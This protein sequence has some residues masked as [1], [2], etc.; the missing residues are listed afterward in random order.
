MK[1]KLLLAALCVVSALGM[2]AQTDVTSTYLTNAD[3]SQT[4]ALD[5]GLC[6]Y[7]KDMGE[8][9]TTYYGLQAI[10]GW[11]S[12][13]LSGDNSNSTYP[14][15]GMG[16]AVFAYGSDQLMMGNNTK[17]P[18]ADPDGNS[19]NCLGF[20]GVWGCGGYYY[21]E[22]TLA[23]GK[24]T[25]NIPVYNQSGTQANTSYIGW[26]P[27]SGTSYT[28]AT[29]PTVGAWTT[30]TASFT[31]TN[32]TTGKICLGYKSTGSGS[33]ANAM[34]YFDKV[35]ILYTAA[36]VK[37]VLSTAL[38]AATNANATLN[39]SD[40]ASAIATAQSV[41]DSTTAT[42]DEVNAAA[43]TL[44][45]A[46]E[47]AMSAAGDVTGIFL[48]NPG[49]E[50]CTVTTSNAAAA[51]N[52]APLD[53][54]GE[55]TQASSA[56]WSSSAV[57]AY[58]GDGQVN[59]ASAPSADNA[60]N[61]GNAL[62]VS[63]GWGGT[64]TYQSPS[65]TLPAGVYTLQVN[66]YNN[67]SGVTQ[68]ASKFGFVPTEGS[69]TLSTKTSFAYATW[70][71]D[72]VTVTLNE[73]TE[74]VIQ[75]GG[76]AISGGSGANAKVF[77][78]NIT[79][80]YQSFLA[81]AKAQWDDAV[82]AAGE[83]KTD[84]PQVTGSEL[85][86]L[87][88]ELAKAEPTTV[89]GYNEAK[90]ALEAATA[91]FIAAAPA[92]NALATEITYA[93]TLSVNTDDATTALN[94]ADATAESVV[95]ACQAL[96][97][98]EYTTIKVA[99]PNDL[100]SLLGDWDKGNYD[101]TKGQGYVGSET[102]FDK[103]S[104]SATDLSS[105]KTVT[106]PA[107]SYTVMVAGRGVSTTT[108]NLS[109]KVGDA[110]AVS[111][112]FLMSGDTGKGIDTE[113]AT[114]FSGEGT[115][116]NNN[117]GRGWQ[118]RYI[119]FSLTDASEVTLSI[120]GHL[121]NG[122]W[123]SFYAPVLLADDATVLNISLADLAAA[124]LAANDATSEVSTL[125]TT[126]AQTTNPA[127]D[128]VTYQTVVGGS[129]AAALAAAVQAAGS[130]DAASIDA[131]Q[132]AT[133]ALTESTTAYN[134]AKP[135]YERAAMVIAIASVYSVDVTA[136]QATIENSE[137]TAE[138]IAAS[139][140]TI[141]ST[142]AGTALA[143]SKA[144]QAGFEKD[145]Y[146]PYNNVQGFALV[147]TAT[148][149][150]ANPANYTNEQL[151]QTFAAIKGYTW[152]Q[153]TEDVDAIYNGMFDSAVEGDWGLTGW[154][155]TNAWGQQRTGIEGDYATAYY[156]QPGSLKYGDTGVY[157]MP[158]AENT[159]YKLTFAY[160][161]HENN[162]NK[163]VTVSVLNGAPEGLAATEFEGNGSTSE[164]K[165]VETFFQTGAAGDYVLTL[166]NSGNTWMTGVSLVKATSTSA[167]MTVKANKWGTFIAPF[168]V[169]IPAGINAY[170]VTGVDDNGYM[171][172]EQVETTIPAN[173]PVVLENTTDALIDEDFE[174]PNLATADS[175]TEGALTGVYTASEIPVSTETVK[176]YVLQTQNDVQAFYIVNDPT[177]AFTATPNRCYLT[178][179]ASTE[180]APRAIFID[181][182]GDATGIKGVD[183]QIAKGKVK[184]IYS[185]NGTEL[186]QLQKGLNIVKMADGKV[187]KVYVK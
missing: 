31:L 67:L 39:N 24:Y 89:E 185:A 109:V 139:A 124:V 107:G 4:T 88:E 55:W 186:N 176:T 156:N 15:S 70:E 142:F 164:W 127:A 30:L 18:A 112:P 144:A 100:T 116:S 25:I 99:Y 38:T 169:A 13:V 29:N 155:R 23:A 82:A 145:E 175:Y 163:G 162:S 187:Q 120:S 168:E 174:G 121:N 2:R 151:Y 113:G 181:E 132:A 105:S 161:S 141:I 61:S 64:V 17:A 183:G 81:G 159:W 74:G 75:V 143:S 41:Y 130:V 60:G 43:A 129:E 137:T 150:G 166:A 140:N 128:E 7:G 184:G 33:G 78:D 42:Q 66:A 95:A 36:V 71:T 3:F 117:N 111:T 53:I 27:N 104:G 160:R 178:V 102:Y 123:Q 171:V 56:A 83:A 59:G 152:T 65:V 51:G 85:A 26:I 46:T 90:E 173:T 69:A 96:K 45:A 182:E 126:I 62:G 167:N 28:F 149:M 118:Y 138:I 10:D 93:Q 91:A 165:V 172:K 158:L 136:L 77:F 103:W 177:A 6:G 135:A 40:L 134:A 76:Q 72:Q 115:Y 11:T 146:A 87:N 19:G 48:A 119:S 14:N 21:Q 79:I 147:E 52:A 157:T 47:I 94:A 108:M 114:N 12:A 50:S 179:E 154:T 133:T 110:D 57:V 68:F 122:T 73:A 32:A 5:N 58:G 63:V 106:L 9:G 170:K 16:G 101:T 22:V 98:L 180:A 44:N 80:T 97:V 92:Y 86:D 49:F 20:F 148:A 37:D 54:S 153:N 1:R 125:L 34:L 131:V 84:Y 35:Q 8:K